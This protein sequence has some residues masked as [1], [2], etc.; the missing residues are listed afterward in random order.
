[1]AVTY[2]PDNRD[3]LTQAL[4]QMMAQ[5]DARRAE[6]ERQRL[7]KEDAD[8]NYALNQ[9]KTDAEVANYGASAKASEA[10][11]GKFGYEV[12]SDRA[13]KIAAPIIENFK[14]IVA[15]GRPEEAANYVAA[16]AKR[17][18]SDPEVQAQ[19]SGFFGVRPTLPTDERAAELSRWTA[20]V[21]G[22][23]AGG[24][25]NAMDVN[26]ATKMAVGEQLSAPAF[27]NQEQREM[28]LKALSDAMAI[29]SDR[30]AG[31]TPKLQSSTQ[32]Q[33][34]REQNAS[35]ER[36]AAMRL[37]ADAA[38]AKAKGKD[39]KDAAGDPDKK[40]VDGAREVV[41]LADELIG[42]AVG[43]DGKA[44]APRPHPG[45]AGAV[46]MKNVF[47]QPPWNDEPYSGSDE[48]VAV[49]K[50][51]QLRAI[52]TVPMLA[53][54]KGLGAM[55]NI[56]FETLRA[57]AASL[58]RN[59][60]DNASFVREVSRVRDTMAQVVDRYERIRAVAVEHFNGDMAKAAEALRARGVIE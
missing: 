59:K 3:Q 41:R 53:N 46:G 20:D 12:S 51:D 33:I 17:Y 56:E 39:D 58:D 50:I 9:R 29:K 43:E 32:I 13:S 16:Q 4:L 25:Q 5:S 10:Q 27:G 54:M 6:A 22:R 23:V 38:T 28:G 19:L 14:A 37:A 8:R 15:N 21:A 42:P 52:L 47:A 30:T 57:G 48:S 1:M 60:N 40:T 44:A 7:L 18:E 24:S 49:G 34:G 45:L 26:L 11:A 2:L 35:A 55:S 36:I 31:A